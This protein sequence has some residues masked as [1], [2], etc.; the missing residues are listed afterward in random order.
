MAVS[1]FSD[2]TPLASQWPIP[3]K[4]FF[5]YEIRP[6][7]GMAGTYFYHSHVGFQAVSAAGPLIVDDA[8]PVPYKYDDEIVVLLQDVFNKTDHNITEGLLSNPF[9]WSG[10]TSNV[11]V[12]GKGQ[13][14]GMLKSPIC[15]L[16]SIHVQHDRIYRIRFIGGTAISFVTLGIEGHDNLTIIEADGS[17]TAPLSVDHLQIGSGQR[18]SVLLR[19]KSRKE[20]PKNQFFMQLETRDRPTMT[21]SFAV[22]NYANGRNMLQPPLTPPI[23]L[24]NKTY[25]WLDYQLRPLKANNGFPQLSEV[26]RRVYVYA[27]QV[28]SGNIVWAQNTYPWVDTFPKEPYLVSLYKN[29][30]VNFPNYY[31]AV[32]N[33]GIDPVTRTFPANIGEVLEIVIQNTG[34]DNG[35]V[36]FHPFHA[37][38]AHYYDIGSGNGTYNIEANEEKLKGTQPVMRDTTMLY[39][40][41]A[42]TTPGVDAGWRAWRLRV[43]QPGVWM[44]H[45]H[46]LQHM[47]MGESSSLSLAFTISCGFCANISYTGMQ[48]VWVMG[49]QTELL[50]IPQPDVSG[51]LSYGGSVYGNSS[52]YPEVVH[53]KN[54]WN[55]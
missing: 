46:I 3:P 33:G 1:P 26:T 43:T 7:V 48:T 22:L 35:G 27:H 42:K 15:E 55:Q 45:C 28:V 2:G 39:R 5:D 16:A 49:N 54:H 11:M 25:D 47:I 4:Y 38:G 41:I 20:T 14:Y 36:D 50:T 30:G 13:M 52:H 17:Y 37:H 34:S 8:G 29:D 23:T 31:S 9:V 53:F 51:Y 6:E 40:Y 44:I 19:T 10:E 12:N 24:P 21:R 32:E 18:F